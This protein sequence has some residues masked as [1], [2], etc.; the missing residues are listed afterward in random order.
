MTQNAYYRIFQYKILNNIL[1]LNKKLY[2][3]GLS[4]T[5]LCSYCENVD[6]DI[7]HLFYACQSTMNLWSQLKILLEPYIT[8]PILNAK[9]ALLGF[10]DDELDHSYLINHI[11]LIFKIYVYSTRI[12]KVL[13]I[14]D[15]KEKILE[16]AR[17]EI[18]PI[19]ID[20]N[21]LSIRADKWEPLNDMLL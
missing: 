12:R 5:S 21:I 14:N 8:L 2:L 13:S 11:L 1:F 4:E 7:G 9:N 3:F 10:Y 16:I 6:E 18:S 19:S 17:L 20:A 15:L